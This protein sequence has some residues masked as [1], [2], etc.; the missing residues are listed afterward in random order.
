MADERRQSDA[1]WREAMLLR[2]GTLETHSN[3]LAIRVGHVEAELDTLTQSLRITATIT[4]QIADDT[5]ALREIQNEAAAA[6]QF[7]CRLAN[8]LRGTLKYVVVPIGCLIA[9]PY[10]LY[11]VWYWFA[12]DYT[13]PIWVQKLIELWK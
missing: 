9:I 5:S 1:K 7:F 8:L 4:Q 3:D 10:L 12:H 2:M 6:R 11:L 13:L